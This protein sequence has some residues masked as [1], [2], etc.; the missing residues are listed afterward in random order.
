MQV[1]A[2]VRAD[3]VEQVG[4]RRGVAMPVVS[5]KVSGWPAEQRVPQPADPGRMS[6]S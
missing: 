5:A 1:Q 6:P 4:T 2:D 3:V